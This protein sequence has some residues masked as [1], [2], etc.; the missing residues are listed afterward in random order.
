MSNHT[1]DGNEAAIIRLTHEEALVLDAMLDRWF[2]DQ[3]AP[4]TMDAFDHPAE[5]AVLEIVIAAQL[6]SQIPA[7]FAPDY[8]QKL[9]RAR[10]ALAD[11]YPLRR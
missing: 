7:V 3:G 5:R 1:V 9:A 8:S 10:E 2:G 4:E 6:D 11:R